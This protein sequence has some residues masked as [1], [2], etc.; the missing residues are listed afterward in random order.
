MIAFR[1]PGAFKLH[2]IF[3]R[4]TGERNGQ[5][6][7]SGNEKSPAVFTAGLFCLLNFTQLLLRR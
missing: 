2:S 4:G 1:V 7:C 3:A 6:L 5:D